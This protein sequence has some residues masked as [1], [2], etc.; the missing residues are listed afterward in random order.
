MDAISCV[1]DAMAVVEN[2]PRQ[3]ATASN[4]NDRRPEVGF[5]GFTAGSMVRM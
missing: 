1:C 3:K 2:A 5:G 4:T